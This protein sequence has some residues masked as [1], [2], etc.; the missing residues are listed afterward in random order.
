MNRIFLLITLLCLNLATSAQ[1]TAHYID[2]LRKNHTDKTGY[3]RVEMPAV[4]FSTDFESGS[5]GRVE[6]LYADSSKTEQNS[7]FLVESRSDPRNP[8][9]STYI[10]SGRWFF[11]RMVGTQNRTMHL[12]FKNT[13]P[14]YP[15]FSY[16]GKRFKRFTQ[17]EC[18][19]GRVRKTFDKDTVYVAYCIPYTNDRLMRRTSEW[20]ADSYMNINVIGFSAQYRPIYLYTFRNPLIDE[21]QKQQVY[22][23]S[24][25][26]SSETPASFVLEGFIDALM[27]NKELLRSVSFH[28]VPFANPD[29]V[30]GG[31][32]RSNAAGVNLEGNFVNSTSPT[33]PETKVLLNTVERLYD[34]QPF[35]VMLDLHTQVAPKLM[36]WLHTA[37]T[38]SEAYYRKEM[39]FFNAIA[40]NNPLFCPADS[41]FAKLPTRSIERW[42][43]DRGQ[44]RTLAQ[45]FEATYE[46]LNTTPPTWVSEENML[47]TGRRLFSALEQFLFAQSNAKRLM[48]AYP[49]TIV[50][51]SNR[52]LIIADGRQIAYND[53]IFSVPY[54]KG[55]LSTPPTTDPG[56]I[57]DETL[58][59]ILYGSTPQEVESLGGNHMVPQIG[60]SETQRYHTPQCSFGTTKGIGRT[61]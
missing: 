11:F 17:Q 8:F 13:D 26:H 47:L 28:I 16:D 36:L 4:R 60:R 15:V 21:T 30:A 18:A 39:E 51:Y 14:E 19:K 12:L 59:K 23:H 56:R 52:E 2:S 41:I 61:G 33:Q 35:D 22:I 34:K 54:P 37:A 43:W 48:K 46:R 7:V 24:R 44:G 10:T 53:T 9:D 5:L 40:R 32:S 29:G 20:L 31:Y 38:S 58:L 45:T 1:T 42:A 6:C 49:Q 3:H 27:E 55:A 57:H 50:G 25:V